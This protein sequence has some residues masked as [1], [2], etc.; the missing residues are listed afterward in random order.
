[1]EYILLILSRIDIYSMEKG[2]ILGKTL[3]KAKG[4]CGKHEN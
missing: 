3:A 2:D 1:V 4:H